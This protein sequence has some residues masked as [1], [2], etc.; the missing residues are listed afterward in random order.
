MRGVPARSANGSAPAALAATTMA[1]AL[2]MRRRIF[3]PPRAR[4]AHRSRAPRAARLLTLDGALLSVEFA[5]RERPREVRGAA[6]SRRV[7]RERGFE[8]PRGRGRRECAALP[9]DPQLPEGR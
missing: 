1:A 3:P 8:R 5:A 2:G 9:W 6:L 4:S 7:E